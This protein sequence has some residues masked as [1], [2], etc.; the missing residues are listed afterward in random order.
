MSHRSLI[1][2]VGILQHHG[3]TVEVLE[4]WVR[5]CE[6]LQ[7]GELA[8]LTTEGRIT[9]YKAVVCGKVQTLR[10]AVLTKTC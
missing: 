6:N 5:H 8:L 9:S 4:L 10:K 3:L 2:C 1:A 7:T